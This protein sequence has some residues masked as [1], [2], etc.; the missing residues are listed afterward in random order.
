MRIIKKEKKL[1]AFRQFGKTMPIHFALLGRKRKYVKSKTMAKL[2]E[3]RTSIAA[4]R[5]K[6][7]QFDIFQTPLLSGC[8]LPL[9]YCLP[10]S[11]ASIKGGGAIAV[12]RTDALYEERKENPSQL[13]IYFPPILGI[14]GRTQLIHIFSALIKKKIKFSSYIRK[15][16][17]EQLQSHI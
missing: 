4:V 2:R 13:R 3:K 11:P 1:A 16:R 7:G 17:M 14:Y 10:C 9:S 6:L 5:A 8:R 15:F 12:H